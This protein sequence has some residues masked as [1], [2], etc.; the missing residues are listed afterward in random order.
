MPSPSE[1]LNDPNYTSAN[2]ETKQAIF[3]RRVATD[4][5]YANANQE[6]QAAI[7]QRFG[8]GGSVSEQRPTAQPQVSG[9]DKQQ[10][11]MADRAK[12]IASSTGL[13]AVLGAAAPEIVSGAGMLAMATPMTAPMGPMLFAAGR[14]MRGSRI[15]EA[16]IGAVSGAV[17]ETAGQAVE[18]A[19]GTPAAG[20]A[21][22]MAGGLAGGPVAGGLTSMFVSGPLK[23]AWNAVTKMAQGAEESVSAATKSAMANLNKGVLPTLPQHDLHS[24]LQKGAEA[25][26]QAAEKAAGKLL[27]DAHAKAA[28]IAASDQAAAQ[29]VVD[30]AKAEAGKLREAAQNRI[31]AIDK[32]TQGK[33]RTADAI[34]KQAEP[35]LAKVGAYREISDIG[36]DLRGK[37]TEVQQAAIAKRT[38]E[39]QALKQTRDAEVTAKE[40]SGQLVKDV[41]EMKALIGELRG[42]LLIGTKARQLAETAG[43]VAPVTEK[44]VKSAYQNVYEAITGNRVEVGTN[45]AGNPVYKTF[46]T[47]F[48]ALDHVRRKLGDAAFGQ[49]KEGYGALGQGIAKDLYQKI[50]KIQK[51]YAPSQAALQET[52]HEATTGMT[53]FGTAAGKKA[54]AVDRM[55]PE[56]FAKDPK[57]LP[58]AYFKSQQGVQDLKELTGDATLVQRAAEDYSVLQ[59]AGKDAKQV[60]DWIANPQQSDW[61]REVPGLKQKLTA[62]ADKL[63]K[64]ERTT[65]KLQEKA[66]AL[67]K[68]KSGLR[69]GLPAQEAKLM[70]AARKEQTARL[71]SRVEERQQL[72]AG[73]EKLGKEQVAAVQAK[74]QAVVKEGFPAESVGKL[75]TGGTRQELATASRYLAGVPGGKQALEGSVRN[76]LARTSPSKL[77]QVWDE[78]LKV[79]LAEGGVLPPKAIAKLDADVQKVLLSHEPKV[80][81][82]MVDRLVSAAVL[83]STRAVASGGGMVGQ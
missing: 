54:T 32:A 3:D 68:E 73:A 24:M 34:L 21:A 78:R 36:K 28:K 22:R 50:S 9:E 72:V 38:Q 23:A 83:T 33:V 56:V 60:R 70:D 17:S 46:P 76:V 47:S 30:E 80:A 4:P 27:S 81:K 49:E 71:G 52:Y 11:T 51:E 31:A 14:A 61:M 64:I 5:S 29:R 82:T 10:P 2:A 75:L 63:E 45:A 67:Q 74:V 6:T 39:Y 58:A 13:G 41:P 37:V 35:E 19:G 66:A 8:V 53:K 43:G 48:D 42:K 44:G 55:D 20:F 57:E 7:R 25:D 26:V 12:S 62:Y 40:M 65:G 69:E 15:A 18:A 77:Q 1:I 59:V 79:A 16:A